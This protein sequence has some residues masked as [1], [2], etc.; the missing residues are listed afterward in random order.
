MYHL[1]RYNGQ[2]VLSVCL[3]VCLSAQ[4]L[5]VGFLRGWGGK[6]GTVR[7]IR[8]YLLG[9]TGYIIHRYTT[10]GGGSMERRAKP[11]GRGTGGTRMRRRGISDSDQ[12][13][14]E[15]FLFGSRYFVLTT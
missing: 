13:Q 12:K 3:S 6:G 14:D 4:G 10:S 11:T 9:R 15:E 8:S 2:L 5:K 7:N 1:L